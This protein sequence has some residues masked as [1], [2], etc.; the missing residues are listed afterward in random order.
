[1]C[2]SLPSHRKMTLAQRCLRRMIWGTEIGEGISRRSFVAAIVG[3]LGGLMTTLLG[4]PIISYLIS[5]GHKRRSFDTWIPLGPVEAL[6][7]GEPTLFAFTRT[8]TSGWEASA[9][10]YGIYVIKKTS[11]DFDVFSNVCTHL[12]CRVSWR[13][14]LDHFF[15]PCHDGHYAK[16]GTV[17]AGPPPRPLDRFEYRVE[18]G[19]LS[20]H[21]LKA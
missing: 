12:S 15:C 13:A 16:D 18:D 19:I 8:A 5:P 11:G 14:D 1:M 6:D 10:S 21:L 2:G 4:L 9:T 20:I 17:L 3:F 7:E